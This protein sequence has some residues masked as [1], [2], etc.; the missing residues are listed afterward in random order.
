ML[1]CQLYMFNPLHSSTN[2]EPTP[3]LNLFMEN[4]E[5]LYSRSK[6]FVSID[7]NESYSP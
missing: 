7:Y 3:V 1:L 4:K 5:T 6:Y 2:Q